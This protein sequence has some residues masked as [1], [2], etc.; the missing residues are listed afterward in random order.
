M[1]SGGI[2]GYVGARLMQAGEDVAFIC[3][4]APLEARRKGG[5]QGKK[6]FGGVGLARITA[7]GHPS[8]IG[9]VSIVIFA[10]KLYDTEK[11]AEAIVPLVGPNTRVV[12]LQNGVDSVDTLSRFV[13]RPQVIGGATYLSAYLDSP[14]LVVSPGG[15]TDVIM[16]GV[17]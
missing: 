7:N 13:P 15:F 6:P 11:A 17:G 8:D 10:V 4:G 3:R 16:G 1:G 2:G 5:L 9:P 14:G 12:T